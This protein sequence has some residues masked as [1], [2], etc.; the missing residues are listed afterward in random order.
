LE[1]SIGDHAACHE[2]LGPLDRLTEDMG[3]REPGAFPFV[4]DEVEALVVLGELE[5]AARL[6]DRL[7]RQG[8]TL[9]RSLAIATAARCRGLLASAGR[10][11][12]E[13]EEHLG[14]ALREHAWVPQPF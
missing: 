3:L 8:R 10:D 14:R 11:L 4:P 13:A 7:K 6:T 9:N 5:A 1:L 12:H 2:W